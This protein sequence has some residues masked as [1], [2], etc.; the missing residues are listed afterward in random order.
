VISAF[1]EAPGQLD[2]V[3]DPI[4]KNQP[5]LLAIPVPLA[6]YKYQL[7]NFPIFPMAANSPVTDSICNAFY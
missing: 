6:P 2:L 5:D 7:M 3:S 4:A 1:P